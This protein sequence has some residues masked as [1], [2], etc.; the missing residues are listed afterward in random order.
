M[1]ALFATR[2]YNP[3]HSDWSIVVNF[4]CQKIFVLLIFGYQQA[5]R[6]YLNTENFPTYGIVHW[7]TKWNNHCHGLLHVDRCELLVYSS[8]QF[9][10][11]LSLQCL[12]FFTMVHV[13]CENHQPLWKKSLWST[14]VCV[15]MYVLPTMYVPAIHMSQHCF[16]YF[17]FLSSYSFNHLCLPSYSSFQKFHQALM[18]AINEGCEG[19]LLE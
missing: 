3:L 6:K 19:I 18:T 16:V 11:T 7:L 10:I 17:H 4:H 5:I 13:C 1:F 2:W 8:W 15:H 12:M 14:C 9:S